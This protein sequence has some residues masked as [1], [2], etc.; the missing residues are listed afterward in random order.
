MIVV[1]P[2]L[3]AEDNFLIMAFRLAYSR[4]LKASVIV[5][6]AG[7]PSGTAEIAKDMD[8]INA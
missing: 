2:R 1:A 6:I 8:D 5:T 7:N 4:A 3:S